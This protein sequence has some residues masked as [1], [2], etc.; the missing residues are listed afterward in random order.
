MKAAATNLMT[1]IVISGFAWKV[2]GISLLLLWKLELRKNY[3]C[4]Q[5]S[6]LVV[7]WVD[8]TAVFF[9]PTLTN[10]H[11]AVENSPAEWRID[12]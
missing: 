7:A 6:D 4:C 3:H 11:R 9:W 10:Y 12:V 5:H 8:V 2:E 1:T